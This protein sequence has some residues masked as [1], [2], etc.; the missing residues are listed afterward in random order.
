MAVTEPPPIPDL[1]HPL[2]LL[3]IDLDKT[4]LGL[5]LA[6]AGGVSGGLFEEALDQATLA[7]ST[8][9]PAA[10]ENDLFLRRFVAGCF[11]IRA[12]REEGPLAATH[13]VRVLAHPP[14]DRT[15]VE[16]RRAILAELATES[17]LRARLEELYRQ[18]RRL[19]ALLENTSGIRNWDPSRRQL[20]ILLI[21]KELFELMASGFGASR[22]GL[23]VLGS[24]G[25]RVLT[26]EPYRAL[27]DLLRYDERL[28]TLSLKVGVGADG[29]IRGF[30]VVSVAEDAENPFVNPP[31]R[32]WLAK[33]E[34]FA[35]GYRFSD[36][37][38]MTRLV[39]AVFMGLEDDIVVLVQLLGDL[40]FYLGAL[41][42]ADQ[43]RAAGLEVCLPELV[44]AESP[45]ELRG[46]F[47]PLLLMSG[48]QPVPCDLV[49][50]RLATTML[51]TGPNSGGK[52]RLLQSVGLTQLLAQSGVFIPARSGAVALAPALVV[53]LIQ[54]TKADQAEGRLGMELLRIRDLF[55]R[56]PPGA[57][58]LL[59]ELC[60]GTN[61]SEG[62]EI[63]ELVVEMLSKLGPQ[64]FITTHF[65]TFAARLEREKKIPDLGF[66][67]VEL[68]AD[69]RATYQF[70]PG[71][72]TTS[73]AGHAAE[74]LGVTGEQLLSLI[75]R[76]VQQFQAK[77]R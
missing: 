38:V 23:G 63:F 15:I 16:H 19:R 22:S 20:D 53:S 61:P 30:E 60:S 40:E 13:L 47:N 66:V 28:A 64:A 21:V 65:L 73:L 2:P 67:Q 5:S 51:V 14:R 77:H 37:E 24:F 58:V 44:S 39:D 6:F 31:W 46:L 36:G 71:V 25:G 12:G 54:E 9:E 74:R 43:A 59:D 8:W 17:V 4:R 56:L 52:T 1:L 34:L 7:P 32:R 35:R 50:S 75:E 49:S 11:K 76:N 41:A 68:G 62:E 18:L 42:F 29:R 48:I 27:S 55:E 3:R 57:M 26:S 33:L 72:A 45:R 69:R 10:F 70:V